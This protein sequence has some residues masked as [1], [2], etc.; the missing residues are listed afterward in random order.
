MSI[1]SV[2]DRGA[3]FFVTYDSGNIIVVPKAQSNRHYNEVL[4][5]FAIDGNVATSYQTPWATIRARRNAKL[6]SSDWTQ[7]ADVPLSVQKKGEWATYR[8]VLRDIPTIFANTA[9][10]VWPT[11]PTD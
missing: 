1:T 10:V 5:W 4:A 8:Q 7:V 2:E 9:D 6:A 11:E 3:A